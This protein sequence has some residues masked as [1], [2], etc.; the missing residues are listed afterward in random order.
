M[1]EIQTITYSNYLF[2]NGR[3]L[4][5][6][7][8]LLFDITDKTP[9]YIPYT[10]GYWLVGRKQLTKLEASRLIKQ[11]SVLVDITHLQWHQQCHLK[12]CFNI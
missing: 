11:D 3:K 1:S 12:E 5:F 8:Q 6:R 10:N 9:K 4:S 7:K 2:F